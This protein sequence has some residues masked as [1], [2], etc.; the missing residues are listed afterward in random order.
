MCRMGRKSKGDRA[1]LGCRTSV[2]V[3]E[4]VRTEATKHNL[5]VSAYMATVLAQHLGMSEETPDV[6]DRLTWPRCDGRT[7]PHLR[8]AGV[9]VTV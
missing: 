3:A 1:L 8:L 5:S 2:R 4:A 9:V 6:C 7:W